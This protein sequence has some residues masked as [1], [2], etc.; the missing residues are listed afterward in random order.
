MLEWAKPLLGPLFAWSAAAPR[1]ARLPVP[2]LVRLTLLFL[3]EELE[4]GRH[5]VDCL[6]PD[7][8]VNE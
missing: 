6:D 1:N 4:S 5:F 2:P 8:E 3:A 7:L